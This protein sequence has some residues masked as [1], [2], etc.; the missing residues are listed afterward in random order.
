MTAIKLAFSMFLPSSIF[1]LKV[2]GYPLPRSGSTR[3]PAF[4]GT[5]DFTPTK[6]TR[7]CLLWLCFSSLGGKKKT[8]KKKG[9]ASRLPPSPLGKKSAL[10]KVEFIVKFTRFRTDFTRVFVNVFSLLKPEIQWSCFFPRRRSGG[11]HT[12][13]AGKLGPTFLGENFQ[14]MRSSRN[15]ETFSKRHIWVMESVT[16]AKGEVV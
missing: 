3:Y 11:K 8:T 6:P 15:V 16:S 9:E 4:H 7:T 12:H 14:G 13:Q 10:K 5:L 1:H 2:E